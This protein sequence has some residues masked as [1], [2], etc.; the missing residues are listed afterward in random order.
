MEETKVSEMSKTIAKD[1]QKRYAEPVKEKKDEVQPMH[2]HLKPIPE[3]YHNPV[4]ILIDNINAV[5]LEFEILFKEN[6]KL[7]DTITTLQEYK[8]KFVAVQAMFKQ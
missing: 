1:M 6:K 7:K 4:Q 8:Q 5:E 3:N 2:V